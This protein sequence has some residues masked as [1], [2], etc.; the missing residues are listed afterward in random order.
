MMAQNPNTTPAMLNFLDTR[1]DEN[2]PWTGFIAEGGSATMPTYALDYRNQ[3]ALSINSDSGYASLQVS[4]YADEMPPLAE[5]NMFSSEDVRGLS[6]QFGNVAVDPPDPDPREPAL[7]PYDPGMPIAQGTG[8]KSEELKCPGC[9][10]D[11]K[12][13]SM[14][15][16]VGLRG[17]MDE[18]E[19]DCRA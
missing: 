18:D 15:K 2:Q 5:G 11:V 4:S 17:T 19:T 12:T 9:G 8:A 14:L 7:S 6:S 1:N 13:K 16:Y 10:K 3:P